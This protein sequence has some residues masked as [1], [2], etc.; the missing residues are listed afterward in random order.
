MSSRHS[1]A[2]DE[3]GRSSEQ[4]LTQTLT[5]RLDLLAPYPHARQSCRRRGSGG[6]YSSRPPSNPL[7]CP[8]CRLGIFAQHG[9]NHFYELPK[10]TNIRTE[11]SSTQNWIL[12]YVN[13]IAFNLLWFRSCL[14][15]FPPLGWHNNKSKGINIAMTV[16]VRVRGD[17]K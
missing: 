7:R 10:Q 5:S 12:V 6:M 4:E 16:V 8:F 2:N 9:E 1:C 15:S 11:P 3:I 17:A 13:F 14:S